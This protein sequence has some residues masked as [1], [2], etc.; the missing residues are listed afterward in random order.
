MNL[1]N[2]NINNLRMLAIDMIE[3]TKSGHPGIALGCAPTIYTLY[4]NHLSVIPDDDKNILRDRF[5]LSAGHGSSILYATLH[6]FGYKI[7]MEDLKKFRQYRSNTPGHPEVGLVP[8]VDVSTGPLGQ[9]IATAVGLA[10]S[11]KL[12]A[13]RFN[14]PDL[15]LF[16]NYTYTLCGEGCLME[17]VSYEALALAGTLK[18]NK[19]IVL[20]DCNKITLDGDLNGV[21]D[22]DIRSYMESLNFNVFEVKDGNDVEEIS[23]AIKNAKKSKDKPNFVIIN[24]HIGFGSVYQDSHKSHGSVLGAENAEM[25][26]KNLGV[27]SSSF[28]LEKDV[29]RD[30]VFL[31]KR[32]DNVKKVFKERLKTYSRAYPGDYKL[33]QKLLNNEWNLDSLLNLKLDVEMSGRDLGA[34]ILNE[35]SKSNPNIICSSADVFSSTKAIIKDSNYINNNFSSRNLKCGIREFAMG[36]ISNGISLYGGLVPI[37]S[38]FMVFSDYL[39]PALRLGSIM[40]TKVVSVFTHDSV[41][42]GEDGPTHQPVEQL[43]GLRAIPNCRVFRPANLS[44]TIASYMSALNYNGQSILALSRQKLTSFDS[45]ISDSMKGGY[46][47]SKENKGVLNAI[48]IATGSEVA[49]ALDVKRILEVGGYNVR[50]VS[51]PCVEIFELQSDRYKESVVPSDFKSVFSIEMGATDT[52]YKYVGKFGKCFGID[53]FGMSA[54]PECIYNDFKFTSDD[55]SK[56]IVKIIKR[57]RDKIYSAISE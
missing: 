36:A 43:C 1:E 53:K 56:D 20:Y 24:T 44:E 7:S 3:N 14:K 25:L 6:A 52:W 8:G 17:G 21:M 4:A 51:M 37:Q 13:T 29:A 46:I 54:S 45:S 28:E 32:F 22:M 19:L 5:V 23:N 15:T 11:Q 16:D 38:T 57:N 40:N 10:I 34:L 49:L 2:K 18:L 26:R 12:M 9:G 55:I 39:K 42:V 31:R 50:V 33:L 48:I 35:I 27:K 41:A 30:F 47:V